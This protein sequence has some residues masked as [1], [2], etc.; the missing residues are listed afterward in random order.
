MIALRN[1]GSLCYEVN[2]QDNKILSLFQ[3]K[4]YM[5]FNTTPFPPL[6]V[7]VQKQRQVMAFFISN[8]GYVLFN[9]IT[10]RFLC[11]GGGCFAW[12]LGRGKGSQFL[13]FNLPSAVQGQHRM[14]GRGISKAASY[15][16]LNCLMIFFHKGGK[17]WC[18]K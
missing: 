14:E 15:P 11:S 12:V 17:T 4:H 5:W 7:C 16:E 18:L 1:L 10:G 13:D 6:D 2:N 9:S 8:L 3:C